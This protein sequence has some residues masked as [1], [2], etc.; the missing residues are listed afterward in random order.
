MLGHRWMRAAPL[1][2]LFALLGALAPLGTPAARADH[3][4]APTAVTIAGS[5]QSEAGCPG[6]WQPDCTSAQLD[7]DADSGKYT[8]TFDV[9]AG[10]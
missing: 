10:D 3:T 2:V 7:L 4:P 8:G 6:D 9:P 5:L 1:L